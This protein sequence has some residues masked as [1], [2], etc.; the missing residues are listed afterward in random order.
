MMSEQ[1]VERRRSWNAGRREHFREL[2]ER[3]NRAN[4]PLAVIHLPAGL[5]PLVG[6]GA[7]LSLGLSEEC[8]RT[9]ERKRPNLL[10]IGSPGA[11]S[12]VLQAIEQSV[13]HPVA[14]SRAERLSLSEHAIATLVI[15]DANRLN[16]TQQDQLYRWVNLHPLKQV[17]ATASE[18]LFPLMVRNVFSAELFFRLNAMS[19]LIDEASVAMA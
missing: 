4:P 2:E 7:F 16:R 8:L 14:S 1:P 3:W 13:A 12:P 19:V 5:G 11:V 9:V 6:L 18:P 15:H 10:L 17:I